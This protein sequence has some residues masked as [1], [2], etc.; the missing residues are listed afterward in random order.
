MKVALG[1]WL[2]FSIGVAGRFGGIPVCLS[3]VFI[4]SGTTAFEHLAIAGGFVLLAI[5]KPAPGPP[6]DTKHA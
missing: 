2:A 6:P 5:C 4:Y 1:M 3:A